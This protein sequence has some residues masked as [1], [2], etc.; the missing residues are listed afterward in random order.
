[1][2]NDSINIQNDR[3]HI[4]SSDFSVHKLDARVY[5]E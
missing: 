2:P 5:Y 3:C 1:M 4:V